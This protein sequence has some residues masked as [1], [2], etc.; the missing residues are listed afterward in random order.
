MLDRQIEN[1]SA[2]RRVPDEMHLP[3]LHRANE[4]INEIHFALLIVVGVILRIAGH[5]AGQPVH[6]KHMEMFRQSQNISRKDVGRGRR[7]LG[8]AVN[9]HD[10]LALPIFVIARAN[11][12]D[13][14]EFCLEPVNRGIRIVRRH[15]RDLAKRKY[16]KE[17]NRHRRNFRQCICRQV[18]HVSSE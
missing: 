9:H 8:A 10:R 7:R 16:K 1:Q 14:D 18:F 12:I 2:A 15:N 13:V 3:Q 11:A 17:R 5:P 4:R 6:G